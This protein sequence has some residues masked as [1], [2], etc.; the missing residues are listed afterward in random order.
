M[1]R[2][3]TVVLADEAANP[4][5]VRHP[6]R[7][8]TAQREPEEHLQAALAQVEVVPAQGQEA[9]RDQGGLGLRAI[10]PEE[11]ALLVG[12]PALLLA[13][14][15]VLGVYVPPALHR[16]LLAAAQSLGVVAP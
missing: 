2:H 1:R 11:G 4:E 5:H 3:A 13:V 15:L 12:G 7:R 14:V 10:A 16:V 9:E 6:P 8:E